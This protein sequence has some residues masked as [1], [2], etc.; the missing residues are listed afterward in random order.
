MQQCWKL[1]I[2]TVVLVQVASATGQEVGCNLM[3]ELVDQVL[4][5][6]IDC[7]LVFFTTTSNFPFL[8]NG[9]K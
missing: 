6:Y 2:L 8:F 3:G 5:R 9:I 7:H 4:K 1:P